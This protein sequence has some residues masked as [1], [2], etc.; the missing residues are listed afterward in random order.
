MK[1]IVLFA[2]TILLASTSFT[3]CKKAYT[4]ECTSIE[5]K[6]ETRDIVATNR[7]EAQK[8][9]DEYGLQGYCEIQ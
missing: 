5:G 7:T 8:N 6:V 1:K 2:T 9:C 4:C 3:A